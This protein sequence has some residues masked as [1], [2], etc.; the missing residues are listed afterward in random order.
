[1]RRSLVVTPTSRIDRSHQMHTKSSQCLAAP[2]RKALSLVSVVVAVGTVAG[3]AVLPLMKAYRC[4]PADSEG[5]ELECQMFS[6][7]ANVGH[8]SPDRPRRPHFHHLADRFTMGDLPRSF[9]KARRSFPSHAQALRCL[10]WPHLS[11]SGMEP[12]RPTMLHAT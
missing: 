1:M 9:L 8:L 10:L 5:H 2:C 6:D 3:L 11:R 7:Y 12:V 4:S